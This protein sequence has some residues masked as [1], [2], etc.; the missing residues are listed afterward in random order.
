MFISVNN[1]EKQKLNLKWMAPRSSSGVILSYLLCYEQL[2]MDKVLV[3]G[4]NICIHT[5]NVTAYNITKLG[6]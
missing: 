1:Q 6:L 4:E 3:K 2:S 5:G